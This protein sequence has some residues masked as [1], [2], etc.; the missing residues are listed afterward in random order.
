M[1]IWQI[2]IFGCNFLQGISRRCCE[3]ITQQKSASPYNCRYFTLRIRHRARAMYGLATEELWEKRNARI[4][5]ASTVASKFAGFKSR[6]LYSVWSTH[7][8]R[9]CTKHAW[10]ISTN[11]STA[12]ELSGLSCITPS[13]QLLC[14]SGVVFQRVSRPAAVISNTVF[15]FDVVFAAITATFLSVIDQYCMLIGRFR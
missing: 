12:S 3:T 9:R 1:G 4:H 11:S 7:C 13:L 6:W 15:D 2:Q 14:I 5:S 10:L 8:K